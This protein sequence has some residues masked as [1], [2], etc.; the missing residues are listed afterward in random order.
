MAIQAVHKTFAAGTWQT[1]A[2]ASAAIDC[3]EYINIVPIVVNAADCTVSV[4]I[5]FDGT[6]FAQW[7]AGTIDASKVSATIP[8]CKAIRLKTTE[9]TSGTPVGGFS[10]QRAS[11]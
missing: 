10:A 3:S 6:N 5:S 2:N 1:G 7:D 9:W 11:F 8:A 4:E